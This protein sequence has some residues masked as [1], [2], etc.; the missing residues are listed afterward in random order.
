MAQPADRRLV[1]EDEL[2]PFATTADLTDATDSLQDQIDDLPAE[3][4]SVSVKSYGAVGDG[5]TVDT[6]AI[7]QAVNENQNV[8]F[9]DGVY[10]I[11]TV[12]RLNDGNR[13][14]GYGATIK[15]NQGY[16][17]SLIGNYES[18]DTTT[19]GYEG[20]GNI[21]VRGLTLDGNSAP[22]RG[23]MMLFVHAENIIVRDCTFLTCT[24]FHSLELNAV[25][26][27][28]VQNCK[29]YGF[30]PDPTTSYRK[31][32]IQVDSARTGLNV[33]GAGDGTPSKN[34]T[35]EGCFFGPD[36][37]GNG[38]HN[39]C[40]G[41]HNGMEIADSYS[42]IR[43]LNNIGTGMRTGG[44]WM[45]DTTDMVITGNSFTLEVKTPVHNDESS[46]KQAGI[47]VYSGVNTVVSG[48]TIHCEP[49]DAANGIELR[50]QSAR[51]TVN[52]NMIENGENGIIIDTSDNC[53]VSANVT[54]KVWLYGVRSDSAY[55]TQV[56]NNQF[57]ATGQSGQN[58]G[59]ILLSG[60]SSRSSQLHTIMGNYG[61]PPGSGYT[62]DQGVEVN[63]YI[64]RIFIVGNRFRGAGQVHNGASNVEAVSNTIS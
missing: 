3:I 16:S 23:D 17:S 30:I 29:F 34:I 22:D 7:Q 1:T 33:G 14:I 2:A 43:I 50:E 12:I 56:S 62:N 25:R 61:T 49:G 27:G 57:I 46:M 24:G 28:L 8:Y 52:N 15:R 18:G 32:A 39:V 64:S 9:P 13:L 38:T 11:D 20:N 10:L 59:V 48:N 54:N 51:S 44:V 36:D 6:A 45:L 35:I 5:V 58:K 37:R 42:N 19:T 55:N 53:L 26:N 60:T 21:E 47:K 40:I 41:G 4:G 63:Q 31:E